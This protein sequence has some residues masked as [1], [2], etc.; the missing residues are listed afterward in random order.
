MKNKFEIN[1][2]LELIQ[3]LDNLSNFRES[4]RTH[5]QTFIKTGEY[6]VYHDVQQ[7]TI[8]EFIENK[9]DIIRELKNINYDIKSRLSGIRK[10]LKKQAEEL[11]NED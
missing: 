2:I 4:E 11:L 3:S 1:K 10:D 6:T 7:F 5:P 8:P 9:D